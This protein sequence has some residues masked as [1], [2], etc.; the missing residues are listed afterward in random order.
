M[1][2]LFF[3]IALI[4]AT[5]AF[6]SAQ[7]LGSSNKL[8]G[9]KD[10]SKKSAPA[11]KTAAPRNSA[12]RPSR[13]KR[14]T[15]RRA[16][17][18]A[19]PNAA[20]TAVKKVPDTKK[21]S[22]AAKLSSEQI[23]KLT[24]EAAAALKV[25]DLAS[26]EEK[27]REVVKSSTDDSS[28][29]LALGRILVIPVP[30][31][32]LADRYEEAMNLAKTVSEKEPANAAAFELLG[33]AREMLGL[34]GPETEAAYRTAIR[35]SP[36]RAATYA[37]LARLLRR[38]GNISGAAEMDAAAATRA[39]K[40]AEV[41]EIAEILQSEQRFPAAERLL[42]TAVRN[43][44]NHPLVLNLLGRSQLANGEVADAIASLKA[45]LGVDL[46]NFD[47]YFRLASAYLRSSDLANAENTLL[48]GSRFAHK[49]DKPVLARQFEQ[50]G[51]AYSKAGKQE[52]ARRSYK[53]ALTYQP[54]RETVI[55][56]LK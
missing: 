11:A 28:A 12:A 46:S 27:Y 13:S 4:A 36:E 31:M 39:D 14:T 34:V 43:E 37:Y 5:A 29:K 52:E 45:S 42:K 8:F 7:D 54:E 18:T 10:S 35:L 1:Y 51:D 49:Y 3:S 38:N 9:G 32:D 48:R 47:T 17:R 44:P 26:A 53:L 30:V 2:R 25:G 33:V 16:S 20:S 40:A 41:A 23:A 24:S 21:V 19:S 56:K 15:A 55:A 22:P 50:L 6:G